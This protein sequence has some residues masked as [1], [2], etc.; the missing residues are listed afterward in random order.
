MWPDIDRDVKHFVKHCIDCQKNK[1]NRHVSAPIGTFTQP[2]LRFEH[3]HIDLVG[4]LPPSNGFCYCLTAV[5]RF[6]R[7]PEAILIT[8]I[9]AETVARALMSGWISR[10]GVP[11][12][13]TTDQGRQ[14]E[15][16]L[17]KA[18]ATLTGTSHIRTTAYHPSANGLV[19]R[20]HRQLKVA[21]KCRDC[22]R[23]TD[24]LPIVLLGIR[25]A[26]KEDLN[27]TAA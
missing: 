25:C 10:F 5:D 9:T 15:S 6:S 13:I 23:W 20:L 16:H 11:L 21:I 26:H 18:L 19:E 1:I 2:D 17:F 12:H 24:E 3:I 14:F 7:W 22:T 27:A 8:D 4:P